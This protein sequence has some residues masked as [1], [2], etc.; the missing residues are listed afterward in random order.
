MSWRCAASTAC[1]PT[2]TATRASPRRSRSIPDIKVVAS[3][4]TGWSQDKG[5]QEIKDLIGSG[6]QIDGIW[7]SGIDKAVVD[8]YKTANVKY[9]P[10]VG[11]DNN[12][13]MGQ[14]SS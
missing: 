7:T 5:A 3:V 6:K 2:P 13:F 14:R 4:F 8:A 1:P 10:V 9:V 11:A 12:G